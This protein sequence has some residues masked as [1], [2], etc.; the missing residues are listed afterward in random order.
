MKEITS[1]SFKLTSK[2]VEKLKAFAMYDVKKLTDKGKGKDKTLTLSKKECPGK[3]KFWRLG[4]NGTE[5]LAMFETE[6]VTVTA[7]E[8]FCGTEEECCAEIKKLGIKGASNPISSH[9]HDP[10]ANDRGE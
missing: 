3:G 1:T 10:S 4:H 8:M 7:S 6:G 9:Q 5:V 2:D